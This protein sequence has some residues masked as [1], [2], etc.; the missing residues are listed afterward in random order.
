VAMSL[1]YGGGM[2]LN[3]VCDA[4]LDVAERPTRPIPSGRVS[5]RLAGFVAGLML[6]AGVLLALVY[7]SGW[8]GPLA[9][10]L[11]L[12]VVGYDLLHHHRLAGLVLMPACR[13]LVILTAAM[14]FPF[15]IGSG[16]WVLHVVAPAAALVL[17]T[18]GVI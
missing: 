10:G 18:A 14:A 5:R 1:I 8:V 13:A 16:A 17:W 15:G 12:C 11:V 7:R 4:K 3:D 9:G 2:V 6:T